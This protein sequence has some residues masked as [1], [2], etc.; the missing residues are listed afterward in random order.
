MKFLLSL[1][2]G[3]GWITMASA[4]VLI[5]A[6]GNLA[7][8]VNGS[9]Q[10]VLSWKDNSANEEAFEIERAFGFTN[11]QFTKIGEVAANTV[12]Y[13]DNNLTQQTQVNYRVRARRTASTFSAYSS[14]ADGVLPLIP[15]MKSIDAKATG[16]IGITFR[17]EGGKDAG[18][19]IIQRRQGQNGAWESIYKYDS[20][21][22]SY[23]DQAVPLDNTEYCYRVYFE[24]YPGDVSNVLCATTLA[25]VPGSPTD[26]TATA[27]SS[28]QINLKWTDNAGNE[29]DF[30]IQRSAD[31]NTFTDLGTVPPNTTAYSHTGLSAGTRVYYRVWARRGA[32]VSRASTNVAD[33]TTPA[34]PQPPAAPTNLAAT[35]VS[36]SQ[37]NLSWTDNSTNE[38]GFEV[39]RS[40]DGISFSKI[41]TIT[42]NTFPNTGLAAAARYYYR[43][44]AVNNAGPSGYSNVASATTSAPPLQVPTAPS[45]LSAAAVS[46]SQINLTWADNSNNETGF[47]VE[48]STD[49]VSFS[50]IADNQP[51]TFSNTGLSA[52][53]KYYY[54]VR[55]VNQAGASGYTN[56]ASATTSAPPVQVPA[57]PSNLS[58]TAVSSSRIDLSW[59]DNSDNETGF[60]VDR[61]TDGISF[62]KIAD[63]QSNTLSN[64]GLPASTKYYYRVRA[65][66]QAGAS[67]YSNVAG[68]TTSPPPK[69]PPAAPSSLSAAAMNSDQ[70]DLGWQRNSTNETGFEIEQSTA[71]GGPFTKIS[72]TKNLKVT[73]LGLVGQTT[74]YFRVRAFNADGYSGYSN[75]ASAKTPETIISVRPP[76]PT[77]IRVYPNPFVDLVQ[78]RSEESSVEV[79]LRVYDAF[80]R[81]QYRYD[82]VSLRRGT[83]FNLPTNTWKPGSYVLEMQNYQGITLKR[84][85]KQP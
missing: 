46:S 54:R 40:T 9:R 74:Y 42:A 38:L 70:I 85:L 25:A 13:T 82:R 1:L 43:V 26:L 66:N 75:V 65:V 3:I 69:N 18:N 30:L 34:L 67:G 76:I 2:A 84:M 78:I 20:N 4:Q 10:V 63:S 11:L 51:N 35:A 6:P 28:S 39:E 21:L 44:R 81:I 45:G 80:G 61:S 55:A 71:A 7:V 31:G 79:D 5:P 57:A 50:K 64:T 41:A 77:E 37:I 36:S 8:K 72:E 33:A 52:S 23:E 59:T 32:Q 73:V 60:E 16:W 15:V 12:T 62:S 83:A 58:A 29:T 56:V 22:K 27:V 17:V 48:R 53:T 24:P 14:V 19:V 47:E 68:A 49:G